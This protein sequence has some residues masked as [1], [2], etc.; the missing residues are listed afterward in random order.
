MTPYRE[1]R[2]AGEYEPKKKSSTKKA[3]ATPKA[4]TATTEKEAESADA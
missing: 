1:R 2:E 3:S 4:E